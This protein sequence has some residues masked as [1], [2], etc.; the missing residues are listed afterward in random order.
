MEEKYYYKPVRVNNFWTNN[1]IEYESN[2]DRNKTQLVE[3]YLNKTSP[4]S[5]GIINNYKNFET[6]KIQLAIASNFISSIDNDEE[7]IMHS[8]SDNIEIM[9]S[10]KADEVIKQLV[11]SLKN[12]YENNL[13]S[14][15]GSEFVFDCVQLLYYK[16]CEMNAN[17]GGSYID[18]PDWIKNK[19]ATLNPIY[20]KDN[21]FFQYAITVTLNHEEI[22]KD[23]QRTTKIKPFINKYNW[24]G[25]NFLS[26]KYDWK[27]FNKSNVAIAINLLH[28]KEGKIYPAY[29][30]KHNSNH[31]KQVTL[32]I[33]PNEEKRKRSET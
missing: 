11:D 19:R 8:K 16:C 30:S 4:Y 28:A 31:E 25:I 3:E 23:L 29:I 24:G 7:R 27:E 15:K 13:E 22:K 2:G 6:R 1:Y 10:D 12:R 5:K 17:R 18:F 26:E 33:I 32:L 9:I 14:M 20:K 21:K